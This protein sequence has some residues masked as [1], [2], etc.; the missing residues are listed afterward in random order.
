MG[1]PFMYRVRTIA[2]LAV[3][4]MLA[5]PFGATADAQSPQGVSSGSLDQAF[6]DM[7]RDPGNLALTLR[8]VELATQAGDLEGAIGALSKLLLS[9]PDNFEV[10][11]RL[12]VLYRALG[13]IS[14]AEIHGQR[15]LALAKDEASRASVEADLAELRK[16][17]SPDR[18]SATVQSGLAFQ[19]N[20]AVA[21][22]TANF[23]ASQRPK[24]KADWNGLL[25]AAGTYDHDFDDAVAESWNSAVSFYGTRQFRLNQDD[26]GCAR[27]TSG[28]TFHVFD[29]PGSVLRPYLVGETFGLG[30][31]L[32]F[33][34]GGAGGSWDRDL[35][36]RFASRFEME[37]VQRSFNNSERYP[38]AS[39]QNAVSI[40]GRATLAYTWPQGD[41]TGLRVWSID[42]LARAGYARFREFGVSPVV[43]FRFTGLWGSAAW[44]ATVDARYVRRPYGGPNP[45]IAPDV[46]RSDREWGGSIAVL[47][48]LVDGWSLLVKASQMNEDSTVAAYSYRNSQATAA[49]QY[50]F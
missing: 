25:A 46:T 33:V 24:A 49:V 26:I 31:S 16:A 9:D 11:R 6:S 50:A 18:F 48:P 41:R 28:P 12:A 32:Y 2:R 10:Q 14:A 20:A 39:E 35:G 1:S 42:N 4:G 36:N 15:A 22:Q 34:T 29:S 38:Q 19:S 17:A 40:L 43:E 47:A 30:D 27:L 37:T 45:N 3:F 44:L 13:S 5:M 8:Y 7:L 21:S 23:V